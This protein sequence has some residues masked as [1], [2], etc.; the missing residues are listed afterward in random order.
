[1][2]LDSR[3]HQTATTT[4]SC[5][6]SARGKVAQ[7]GVAALSSEGSGECLGGTSVEAGSSIRVFHAD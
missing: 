4:T 1:M 6:P 2:K 5:W 3:V 7:D